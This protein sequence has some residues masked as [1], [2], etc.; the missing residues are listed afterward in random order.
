VRRSSSEEALTHLPEEGCKLLGSFKSDLSTIPKSGLERVKDKH[1]RPYYKIKYQI[2]ATFRS[3]DLS[4]ADFE[5]IY[6]GM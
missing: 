3:A 1:G 6:K 4:L 2:A 5:L